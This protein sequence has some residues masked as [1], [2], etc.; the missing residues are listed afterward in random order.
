[1]DIF[2]PQICL[3]KYL[4]NS[5]ATNINYS[6]TP[7]K[8]PVDLIG[9]VPRLRLEYDDASDQDWFAAAIPLS[10]DWGS[11]DISNH[12]HL[13]FNIYSEQMIGGLVRL[14]DSEGVESTDFKL[15]KSI[16]PETDV[17]V[18]VRIQ[19]LLDESGAFNKQKCRL[20]K[21]IGYKGAAF[22]VSEISLE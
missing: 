13:T 14:E 8:V 21:I 15:E 22:Y 11:I 1:M 9:G 7:E 19:A 4:K 6:Q 16:V 10:P 3:S 20:L 17:S 2:N 18:R 5:W 12:K